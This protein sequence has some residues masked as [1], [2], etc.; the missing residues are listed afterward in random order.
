MA[1][2][3]KSTKPQKRDAFANVKTRIKKKLNEG[4]RETGRALPDGYFLVM[5]DVICALAIDPDQA[6]SE[7]GKFPGIIGADFK[8]AINIAID[9]FKPE[10]A[11]IR[12]ALYQKTQAKMAASYTSRK[13]FHNVV[14]GAYEEVLKE[15]ALAFTGGP[16]IK[17]NG[18]VNA[19]IHVPGNET[20]N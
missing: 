4:Y 9:H 19:G 12:D 16:E 3:K 17:N 14:Y 5:S 10:I 18:A 8:T 6:K 15:A 13:P 7:Y 2:K 1:K 20:L 11:A